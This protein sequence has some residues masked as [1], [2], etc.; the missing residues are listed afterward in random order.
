MTAAWTVHEAVRRTRHT[1][2]G[3]VIIARGAAHRSGQRPDGGREARGGPDSGL[4]SDGR[5]VSVAVLAILKCALCWLY[6]AGDRP[7]DH[8]GFHRCRRGGCCD[9]LE[10]RRAPRW[11]AAA[12]CDLRSPAYR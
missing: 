3:T 10:A 11:H 12:A 2:R 7:Y 6:S 5:P 1:V 4:V 9:L 8:A